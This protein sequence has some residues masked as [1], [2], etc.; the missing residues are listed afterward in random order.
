MFQLKL[1]FPE[2]FFFCF[3]G[4]PISS[5]VQLVGGAGLVILGCVN[6]SKCEISWHPVD[7][8]FNKPYFGP[9]FLYIKIMIHSKKKKRKKIG[10]VTKRKGYLDSYHK[11]LI[12]TVMHLK[13]SISEE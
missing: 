7:N 5:S 6:Q 10:L 2:C 4:N 13:S 3:E 11:M 12:N 8:Y 9:L 1:I